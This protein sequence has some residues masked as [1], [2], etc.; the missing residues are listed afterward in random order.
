MMKI[1][2]LLYRYPNEAWLILFIGTYT[3]VYNRLPEE[4]PLYYSQVLKED[5]LASKYELLL[6]PGIVYFSL[7]LGRWLLL[8]LSLKNENMENLILQSLMLFAGAGYFLFVRII[9]S[10]W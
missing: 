7:L 4:I 9:I 2:N 5:K 8:K 10:V 1:K 3:L 6:I